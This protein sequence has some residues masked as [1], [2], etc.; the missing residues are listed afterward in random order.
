MTTDDV[1]IVA[2]LTAVMKGVEVIE[3]ISVKII[4]ISGSGD[5]R[6]GENRDKQKEVHQ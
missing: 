2:V 4:V 1:R 3:V 6:G 5:V